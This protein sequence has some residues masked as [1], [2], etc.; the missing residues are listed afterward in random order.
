MSKKKV[1]SLLGIVIVSL[2]AVIFLFSKMHNSNHSTNTGES[3]TSETIL[4]NQTD[5]EYV[6]IKRVSAEEFYD[7]NAQVLEKIKVDDSVLEQNVSQIYDHL[8]NSGFADFPIKSVY[9]TDGKLFVEAKEVLRTSEEKYPVYETHYVTSNGELWTITIVNDS[10]TAYPVSY[11]LQSTRHAE[12][13]FSEHETITVY[14]GATN[15]FYETIPDDSVLIVIVI[16]EIT[17]DALEYYT[18]EVID[19]L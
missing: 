19:T 6:P 5:Y 7:Q 2:S 18:V 11:N 13:I 1:L 8:T 14:D 10:I 16:E 15:Q 3:G 9:S 12:L 17:T 4:E